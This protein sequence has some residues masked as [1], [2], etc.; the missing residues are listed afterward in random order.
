MVPSQRLTL[1]DLMTMNRHQLH[2]I[3]V[4]AHPLDLAA[5]E[6]QQYQG[7]DLSLPPFVNR[8]LWKTFRK[9]FHRDPQTGALRG[10]NVRME[11][12]G[13]D[14][15]RLPMTGRDG[16]PR[17]FAHYEVR[18]AQ[19]LRFPRGWKG[20][21]YLDYGVVGNPFG[22]NLGYTP[23]VAV[24]EGHM[25]L[26]LGWEVFKLGPLF[27]PLPDYWALRL[28]GPVEEVAPLPRAG[29]E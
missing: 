10:W 5:L 4:Q 11:Q 22:E 13:I 23:L 27:L 6:E 8:I 20:S 26:L 3:I 16:K 17:T 2:A 19:G 9:T 7:I 25:D 14:G 21:H 28:E 1:A 12:H 24:N 29:R 18:S 15:P